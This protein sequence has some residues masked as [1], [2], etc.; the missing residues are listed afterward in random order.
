MNKRW[1]GLVPRRR[2]SELKARPPEL[3]AD[4]LETTG[5]PAHSDWSRLLGCYGTISVSRYDG[6]WPLTTLQVRGSIL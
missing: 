6:T 4:V 2:G 5:Q 1:T 3:L